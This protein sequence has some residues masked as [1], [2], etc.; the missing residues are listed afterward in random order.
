MTHVA[1][2]D[3]CPKGWIAIVLDDGRFA[4]A[5]FAATFA[6]LLPNLADAEVIAVDIPIG[7]P[8]DGC[9]P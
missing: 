6:D 8:D 2:V 4:R 9:H 5:E 1:G 7:L 3:G